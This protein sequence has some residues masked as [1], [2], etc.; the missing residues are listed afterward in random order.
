MSKSLEVCWQKHIFAVIIFGESVLPAN[1]KDRQRKIPKPE[2]GFSKQ[3]VFNRFRFRAFYGRKLELIKKNTGD[4]KMKIKIIVLMAML[5]CLV[6][7]AAAQ[8][9]AKTGATDKALTDKE[10]AAWKYLV[11]KKYDD[12][13]KMFADDYTG[14]YDHAVE[15]KTS[16]LT[17]VKQITFKSADVTD[18]KVKMLDATTALVTANVKAAMVMPDGTEMNNNARTTT[19]YVRRGKEWL[20]VYHSDITIKTM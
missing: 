20:I 17:G 10:Q 13:A 18:I 4:L 7:S 1:T 15:T 11:D 9:T 8:K 3:V 5:A 14:V 6:V 19:I 12:F 2:R 16:E